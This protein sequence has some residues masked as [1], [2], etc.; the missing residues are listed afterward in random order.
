M[1]IVAKRPF[2]QGFCASVRIARTNIIHR[3]V[4]DTLVVRVVLP[5]VP[6]TATV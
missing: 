3:T 6:V 4:T 1:Q 5:L 2:L